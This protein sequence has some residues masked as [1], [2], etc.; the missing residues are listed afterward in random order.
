MYPQLRIAVG[1]VIIWLI[2]VEPLSAGIGTT[3]GGERGLWTEG[4]YAVIVARVTRV[5][6]MNVHEDRGTHTVTLAPLA[7][8]AGSIDPTAAESVSA[9]LYAGDTGTKIRVAP[10][11]GE[12]V[13]AV[14]QVSKDAA[15][16]WFIVSD[17]CTFMPNRSA[18]EVIDGLGD[19]RVTET[20]NRLREARARA[21]HDEKRN[22]KQ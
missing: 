17:I 13:M 4:R 10:S 2:L 11:A 22:E 6:E 18:L 1:V 14:V 5:V 15:N 7:T 9:T 12:L 21:R 19:R 3:T 8:L 20:A 16:R